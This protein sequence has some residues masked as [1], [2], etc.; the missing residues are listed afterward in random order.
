MRYGS[1]EARENTPAVFGG[2]WPR[3]SHASERFAPKAW[4][5]SLPIRIPGPSSCLSPVVSMNWG[6][7]GRPVPSCGP[8]PALHIWPRRSSERMEGM[9]AALSA[10]PPLPRP[11]QMR[12]PR[13]LRGQTGCVPWGAATAPR[14]SHGCGLTAGGGPSMDQVLMSPTRAQEAS[15]PIPEVSALSLSALTDHLL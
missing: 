12:R 7:G 13:A 10:Q 5:Y 6:Q 8:L 9:S 14:G 11:V 1:Q 2:L 4:A 15:Q 3:L